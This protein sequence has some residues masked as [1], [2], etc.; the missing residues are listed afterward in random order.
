MAEV[1][2]ILARRTAS[3]PAFLG[4]VLD[5]YARSEALDDDGLAAALHC[6]RADLNLLRL[7][8]RPRLEP[9]HFRGDIE[10]IAARFGADGAVLAEAVRRSD[11]LAALRGAPAAQGTLLAARDR[12]RGEADDSEQGEQP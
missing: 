6:R 10:E 3:D 8:L 12:T 9:A 2:D 4:Q 5:E 11:A 1:L 7:C